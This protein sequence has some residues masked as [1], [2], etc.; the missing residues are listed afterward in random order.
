LARDLSQSGERLV[1]VEQ[2]R[3]VRE[4]SARSVHAS[5][6]GGD[7]ALERQDV[8]RVRQ[9]GDL[10]LVAVV[11]LPSQD[12]AQIF[13]SVAREGGHGDRGRVG[14]GGL[15]RNEVPLVGDD[16]SRAPG[17]GQL[18]PLVR[19]RLPAGGGGGGR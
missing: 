1:Q 12:A 8:T 11:Q 3:L 19:G 18:H 6:E 10:R 15:E 5:R 13:P 17:G 9:R 14:E 7:D 4:T 16:Q 2:H